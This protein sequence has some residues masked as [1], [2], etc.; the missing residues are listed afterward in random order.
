[1]DILHLHTSDPHL[2]SP[3]NHPPTHKKNLMF[4]FIPT[5]T[6]LQLLFS[7][8]TKLFLSPHLHP[9]PHPS[10]S[11]T[12]FTSTLLSPNLYLPS[13]RLK[14]F[15]T[16]NPHPQHSSRIHVKIFSLHLQSPTSVP[17]PPVPSLRPPT[18]SSV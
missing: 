18:L 11:I 12:R 16:S 13:S 7:P 9:H 1:M 3:P 10:T 2:P 17:P 5:T 4:S 6:N 14:I 15:P 8:D